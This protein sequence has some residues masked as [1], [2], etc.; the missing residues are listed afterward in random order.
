MPQLYVSLPQGS[1]PSGTPV[2]VLRGFDKVF[3]GLGASQGVP[4]E[5]MRR[6]VSFRDVVA[7][8]WKVPN[9]EI[10]LG[11]G[12]STRDIQAKASVSLL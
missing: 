3:L 6:D 10:G 12:L 1:T 4:F 7:Q 2:Q 8:D 11:V 5:L 9:G